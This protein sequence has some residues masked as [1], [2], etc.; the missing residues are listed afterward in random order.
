[1]A[2]APA[3]VAAKL[4]VAGAPPNPRDAML[5]G[6]TEFSVRDIGAL[7]TSLR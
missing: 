2:A 5:E 3:E 1:M 6:A 4:I 7:A